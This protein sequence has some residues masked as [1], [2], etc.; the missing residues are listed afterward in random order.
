LRRGLAPFAPED[1]V[2]ED[3][4]RARGPMQRG[5]MGNVNDGL[6]GAMLNEAN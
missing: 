2:D 6:E 1:R 5:K 3:V 4:E